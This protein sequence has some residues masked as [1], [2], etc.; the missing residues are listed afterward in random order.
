MEMFFPLSIGGRR[1]A[2]IC[3]TAR[4]TSVRDSYAPSEFALLIERESD[5]IELKMG[6]ST[7][8]LQ[9]PM[10]AFSN[11]SGGVILI[12]VSDD[13]VVAGRTLDQGTDDQIHQA[14][15]AAA[16]LGRYVVKAVMV[17]NRQIVAVVV[18]PRAEGFSQTSDG[19]ILVRRGARN[20][21]LFGSDAWNFIS[22]RALRRFERTPTELGVSDSS[23]PALEALCAVYG[24]SPDDPAVADRLAER[25]LCAGTH[26]TIAGALLLTDPRD[27]MDLNKA[28]VEVRRYPD[29]G[30]NYNRRVEFGG[31]LPEQIRDTTKFIVDE[32]G[33]DLVVTGVYRHE[34]PRLPEVVV[35]ETIA[36]AVAHRSYEQNRTAVIVELRPEEVTVHSPGPLP[37]PVT[38]ATIRQAQAARN[39]DVIDSLRRFSLAEDAGRGIDVI[40]DAMKEALLD[41]PVF[42]D[43]GASV[44]VR[45]PLRGPITPQER[46]WVSELERTGELTANDRLL[47]VHA[48]RGDELA[49]ATAR[50]IL[51]TQDSSVARLALQRLRDLGLLAQ[52]GDRGGA[53]YTLVDH[54]APA[55]AYRL[56][57]S[58]IADLLLKAAKESALTNQRVRDLTGLTREHARAALRGLVNQGRLVQRGSR[59]GTTYELPKLR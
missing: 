45:L 30:P 19:R 2:Y 25:G 58:Q 5:S 56:S 28:I 40:E 6:V 9:E 51:G 18:Q 42:I 47:L 10:V 37:E 44:T 8:K 53:T 49:N 22:S 31:T 3:H 23:R 11:G 29:D 59:R 54:F 1:F 16:N 17:G 24:W 4:V 27:S 12:G 36:N 38:V 14:A 55:V 20:V 7:Y 21:A 33:S 48:A 26:L 39:P 34:I 41:A 13:R 57:P 15:L 43:D 46:A 50:E 52:H 32:L 35:R